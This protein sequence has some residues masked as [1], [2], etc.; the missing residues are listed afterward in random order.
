MRRR[1]VGRFPPYPVPEGAGD[2][3]TYPVRR[4]LGGERICP[5]NCTGVLT[6]SANVIPYSSGRM[7][8]NDHLTSQ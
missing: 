3:F 2:K 7:L 8:L 6:G 5:T 4:G 1:F